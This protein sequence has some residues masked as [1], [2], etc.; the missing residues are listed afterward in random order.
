MAPTVRPA[1]R[2][3]V[4]WQVPSVFWFIGGTDPDIYVKAK[5]A[6]KINEIPSNHSPQFAPRIHPTLETGLQAM[7]TAASAWLCP[8]SV[9]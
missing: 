8:G 3:Q 5:E 7:L 2:V 6:G 1:R 9:G 4:G